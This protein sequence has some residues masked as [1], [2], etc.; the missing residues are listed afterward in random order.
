VI[1]AN[2]L[3]GC[4][5]TTGPSNTNPAS[6]ERYCRDFPVITVGDIVTVHSALLRHLQIDRLLAVIGGSL[7]GMQVLEWAA[8]FPDQIRGAICLAAGANLLAQGIASNAVGQRAI[9]FDPAFQDGNYCSD[10]EDPADVD[11]SIGRERPR[12]LVPGSV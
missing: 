12:F 9:V 2:A 10:N 7:G 11:R 8:R 4:Q 3:G 5:G 1:C 6:G